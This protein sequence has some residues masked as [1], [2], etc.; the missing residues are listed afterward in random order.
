MTVR[1]VDD[2]AW[3]PAAASASEPQ[4]WLDATCEFARAVNRDDSR[5]DLLN[6]IAGTVAQLTS[7][8]F[9]SV[10]LP[11]EA[12]ESLLIRGF[13]GLRRSYVAEVNAAR[14]PLIRPGEGAEGPSSRAFR[15]QRPVV[16]A[17]I[18]TDPTCMQWE[19]V[20]GEQGYRSILSLPLVASEGSL[21]V[22]AC[23]TRERRVFTTQELVFMETVANH[24]ALAIESSLRRHAEQDRIRRLRDR[25]ESLQVEHRIT[26]RSEEV[27]RELMRL[28]LAGEA[29]ERITRRL[30][31]ALRSDVL[32]QDPAGH[33]LGAAVSRGGADG[34]PAAAVRPGPA[35][36]AQL[37]HAWAEHRAVELPADHG[38]STIL[39][40]PVIL[41]DE[42]AG[43][44]WAFN[45]RQ[46]FAALERGVLER[47]ALVV[48]LAV[49]K[50]RA[51][52]EVEWRLSGEFLD[53]LLTA[54]VRGNPESTAARAMQL[55]L[56]L[57]GPCTLLVVRPD[58]G[59]EDSGFLPS[60]NAGRLK[61][62]LL[63]QVQRIVDAAGVGSGAL[64]AARAEDV[65]VLWPRR[66]AQAEAAELAELL[67]RQIRA[68]A[69]PVSVGLGPPCGSVTEYA[70]AHRLAAG[71][72]D[73][74]HRAGGRERVVALKDL[75]IYRPL[76][77][78]KRPEE[79]IEFMQGLLEPLYDYDRRHE[80]TLVETLRAFLG[81]GF[82]TVATAEALAVHPN[83]VSYRLRR[84]EDL[85]GLDCHDAQALLQFQLAFLI[86]SVLGTPP[87][88]ASNPSAPAGDSAAALP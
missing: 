16:L 38:P 87:G 78:V 83:T 15:T 84:I 22:L 40:A 52:Q 59:D 57:T 86:E 19:A 62:S 12:G 9:C 8:D 11:D 35:V 34:I 27:Y 24:A 75:G 82:S 7:Y 25:I 45:P 69:G 3:P 51:A 21:G 63:T 43:R 54:D 74:V 28:L 10:L 68:Y 71:A 13:Y 18:R 47:G 14:P 81:H 41:D 26:Q 46:S 72:L 37:R 58:P 5:D 65:V 32:I 80:T 30:A 61:R 60:G 4:A 2:E 66:Q 76:L 31:D 55:G 73:L 53:D 50:L 88:A 42:V 20:A 49:S 70:S 36:E 77:Q 17:D 64:V 39:V 79:L 48:A 6:L 44:V 23:Y 33:P 29:L 85:L 1:T 67:R 56:D